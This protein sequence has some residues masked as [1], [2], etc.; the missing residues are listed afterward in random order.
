MMV[1][2]VSQHV[3]A[4]LTQFTACFDG[5]TKSPN[6][7]KI[8]D[9]DNEN[10]RD[11]TKEHTDWTQSAT[12]TTNASSRPSAIMAASSAR[13]IGVPQ[14]SRRTAMILSTMTCDG[15]RMPVASP[16]QVTAGRAARRATC[17]SA[18]RPAH[19]LSPPRSGL[20]DQRRSRVAKI[21]TEGSRDE[22]AAPHIG[23]S[24]RSDLAS[25]KSSASCSSGAFRSRRACLFSL[26]AKA[27]RTWIGNPEPQKLHAAG[28]PVGT[29]SL[30]L[31]ETVVVGGAGHGC[32][33]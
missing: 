17:L 10:T 28:A 16:P 14:R 2:S 18:G 30:E 21:T 6:D 24:P 1:T 9:E 3:A 13:P 23:R 26:L 33:L 11:K 22:I 8:K 12:P 20:D 15:S 7:F 29:V 4:R 5:S 32:L 25:M 19:C 27:G 31:V